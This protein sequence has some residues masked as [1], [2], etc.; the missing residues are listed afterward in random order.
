VELVPYTGALWGAPGSFR[1]GTVEQKL[2]WPPSVSRL[3][4][5][6]APQVG[7]IDARDHRLEMTLNTIRPSYRAAVSRN[8]SG[9]KLSGPLS[10]I[11]FLVGGAGPGGGGGSRGADDLDMA[12]LRARCRWCLFRLM[13]GQGS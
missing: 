3:Q 6:R 12:D 7:S 1:V 10:F 13:G 11:G 5:T 9:V 4:R 8:V 2:S